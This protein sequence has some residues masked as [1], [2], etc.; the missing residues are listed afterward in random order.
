MAKYLY[1]NG[2]KVTKFDIA[3][4]LDDLLPVWSA[5]YWMYVDT[6]TYRQFVDRL[7]DVAMNSTYRRLSEKLSFYYPISPDTP[8]L[9]FE[10]IHRYYK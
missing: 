9:F 2:K 1:L 8:A 6:L 4:I 5:N 7:F 10:D 3:H